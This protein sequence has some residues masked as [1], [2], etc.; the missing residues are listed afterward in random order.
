[1]GTSR[2]HIFLVI[3]YPS[4]CGFVRIYFKCLRYGGSFRVIWGR[5][6]VGHR[7][8]NARRVCSQLQG[9]RSR[10]AISVT[11]EY[12]RRTCWLFPSCSVKYNS[13]F[14]RCK[15]EL[16]TTNMSNAQ[17]RSEKSFAVHKKCYGR[18]AIANS[19][20][21]FSVPCVLY[22]TNRVTRN[23]GHSR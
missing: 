13:G 12:S 16:N 22:L 11:T 4:T 5:S 15:L 3:L 18:P 17:G 19:E 2:A 14:P 8:G 20:A 7:S 21:G 10:A 23:L 6:M 1:M 9:S